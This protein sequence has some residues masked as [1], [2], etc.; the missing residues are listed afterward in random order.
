MSRLNLLLTIQKKNP[1]FCIG[2]HSQSFTHSFCFGLSAK[3]LLR[4]RF[5][6][7]DLNFVWGFLLLLDMATFCVNHQPSASTTIIDTCDDVKSRTICWAK[8]ERG[9]TGSRRV[10]CR[11]E[12]AFSRGWSH[13]ILV[14]PRNMVISRHNCST[15]QVLRFFLSD[16]S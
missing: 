9:R 7:S 11:I 8:N 14:R 3:R 16:G 4:E 5:P 10:L 12:G 15:G 1:F 13:E 6:S 2:R